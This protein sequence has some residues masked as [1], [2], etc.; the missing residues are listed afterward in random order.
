M[1]KTF[2]FMAITILLLTSFIPAGNAIATK[3][4]ETK[5]ME[6]P[7]KIYT[8]H[9]VKEIK[10]ELPMNEAKELLDLFNE[11]RDAV[12]LMNSHATFKE[13]M[14]ANAI[15][16]SLIFKMKENGL[17]GNL[18][19][20]EAKELIT[21]EYLRGV[22]SDLETQRMKII[23]KSFEID[24]LKIN[25]IC[26]FEAYGGIGYFPWNI[27]LFIAGYIAAIL[28]PNIWFIEA[29]FDWI[30]ILL[31]II[32]HLTTVGY[33]KIIKPGPFSYGNVYVNGL[34][35]EDN[36][37]VKGGE[38][39]KAITIGFT[40]IQIFWFAIGFCPFIAYKHFSKS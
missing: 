36:I 15:I 12:K 14:E 38:Y 18:S 8:L 40:G 27:P 4:N 1:N 25:G 33:W 16:D 28:F 29:F 6:V 22:R 31:N 30:I 34:L 35:G 3:E 10:K 26:Y 9:G 19:I 23:L 20:K 39:V 21:G 32:P 7:V 5:T 13:K 11:T 2:V 17:L 37:I 24:D